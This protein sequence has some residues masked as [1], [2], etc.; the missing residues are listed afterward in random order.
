MLP[1][2]WLNGFRL[3]HHP[4]ITMLDANLYLTLHNNILIY[5]DLSMKEVSVRNIREELN[6]RSPR[7][8]RELCLRLSRFKKENKELLIYILFESEDEESY[9]EGIKKEI[10]EKFEQINIENYSYIKK[11]VRKILR[12]TRKYIRYSPR[13][14]TEVELLIYFCQ[15]LKDF[16][17]SIQK[18]TGLLNLYKRQVESIARKI[19]ILHEDL[20]FDF[21]IE[22]E[23]LSSYR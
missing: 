3:F 5:S 1:E 11:G 20:Q 8:L 10:N 19:S 7:E 6:L 13:K 23:K 4:G 17:P 14:Q 22:L 16:Y 21:G 2:D 15:K 9:I 18:N 12:L